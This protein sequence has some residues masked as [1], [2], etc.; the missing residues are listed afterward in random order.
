MTQNAKGPAATAIAPDHGSTS[1]RKD[2]EMNRTQT[3]T[4]LASAPA[5]KAKPSDREILDALD[6]VLADVQQLRRASL[7]L[8]EYVRSEF[9]GSKLEGFMFPYG[10]G[11]QTVDGITY[12]TDHVRYLALGLEN[13]ID[14]AFGLEVQA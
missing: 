3:N 14:K 12:M 1:P 8:D 9:K 13:A 6:G 2:Q 7:V 5:P 10:I 4:G 11:N